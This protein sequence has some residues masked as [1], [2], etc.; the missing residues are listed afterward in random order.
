LLIFGVH[1]GLPG[2]RIYN[3]YS[4][5][6]RPHIRHV[7]TASVCIY[8]T[9]TAANRPSSATHQNEYNQPRTTI[10]PATLYV[11]SSQSNH[12][13]THS[14]D[15]WYYFSGSGIQTLYCKPIVNL[16]GG[17]GE[18]ICRSGNKQPPHRPMRSGRCGGGK[19]YV[20]FPTTSCDARGNRSG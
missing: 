4:D 7:Y 8:P 6:S 17:A 16:S 1:D 19:G 13:I 18:T 3:A 2:I 20:K 5:A 12:R 11:A 15:K 9:R 10:F 14:L